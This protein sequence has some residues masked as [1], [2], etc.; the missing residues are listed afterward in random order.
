MNDTTTPRPSPP[1]RPRRR[2]L[3]AL[4]IG[5][6]ALLLLLGAGAFWLLGTGAGLRFALA[7][8]SG[9]TDGALHVG[10]AEG[11]LLGPLDL[12][13]IRYR[14]GQGTDIRIGSA[15]ADLAF[16]PLLGK[17]LHVLNL[18]ADDI[19]AALHAAKADDTSRN[20]GFNLQPPLDIVLD[21]VRIGRVQVTQG[22]QPL[23]ASNRLDLAGAWTGHGITVRQLALQSPDGHVDLTGTLAAGGDYRGDG[24]AGFAWKLGDTDY[25]GSLQAH[26]DGRRAHL[27]LD[28]AQPAVASLKLDLVQS[29]DY[30]WTASLDAPRFDPAP[31]LG[32]GSL[33]ALAVAL[34]GSGDRRGGRIDGQVGLND[35]TVQIQPLRAQ[36]SDDLKTLQLEQLTLGSPQ[37]PGSVEASGII[38]LDATPLEAQLDIHWKDLVLPASLVGQELASAGELSAEGSATRFHAE[39]KASVGPPGKTAQFSLNLDGTDR[40]IDLHTL[41]L[42][43]PKGTLQAKGTV[44]LRPALGWNVEASAD[45][46]DPGQLFAGWGGALDAELA[47]RG[48]SEAAGV[49]ATLDLRQLDGTL[50]QR[51]VRGKGTLHLSSSNVIDGQLEL[52][53]GGSTIALKGRPG[54]SNDADV[55]LAVASLGD[56][57]PDAGGRVNGHFNI[58]GK[59]PALSVNGTLSGQKI[60][61]Q[62]QKIDQLQL[63]LGMPDISKPSGKLELTTQ[64]VLAGGLSFEKIH[65]LAEGSQPDHR[66]TLDARGSQ[67]SAR[68][69]LHGGLKDGAWNGTLSTLQLDPQGLPQWRLQQPSRLSWKD[70]AM[71]ASE[72]CL[73][74]G[75]PLICAS[76]SQ[77]KGGNL[78]ASYRLRALPLALIINAAG[79]ADLPMRVDG[80]LA[81]DGTVH[82]SA[83]GAL[84]GH[85]AITSSHGSVSYTDHPEQPLLDYR[86][87]N[88]Q[89]QLDGASQSATVHAELNN[90]GLLD[91]RVGMRGANQALDGTLTL[92]LTNLAFVELLTS[93]VA[94][95]KGALD[96]QFRIGGT[97]AQ[98][99]VTGQATL[100]GFAGEV[101]AAGLKLTDGHVVLSTADARVFRIDGKVS[102][103]QGSLAIAGTAGLG[104]D[105]STEVTLKGSQFTAAD[106]PSAKVVVS[107]DLVIKQSAQGIDVGGKVTLDQADVN[108]AKL[109]GAGATQ[110]SPDVVV[111]DEKQQQAA[112]SKMPLSAN[113]TV[114]LG[115]KTHVVGMGLDG[116]LRGQLV[117]DERPGRAT[118]G[119]G[120]IAVS[121]TYKAYG[122]NLNIETGQLLFASTPVD[123]P[124]L[125]IRAVRRLNPNATI[126]EGQKVGLYISG[127]AQRPVLTVFSQPVME[128]SDALSYLITG[129][130]LSEVKGGE[131][132]M[133]NSAA[134]ALGSAGGDLLAKRIGSQLGVDDIGV[135][136]SDALN[137]GSAFTVGKY[138][139]PRLYLSYGV[140]LFDP[141]QVITL[142]YRI[143]KRWNFEAQ[144]AT[145]FSRASFNYRLEK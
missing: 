84:S 77:D 59:L 110:S 63:V 62:L 129:K 135:S 76:A 81:G 73:T 112:A 54:D 142:R 116:N 39:G 50:R 80:E 52:A 8:A 19:V 96:G 98:P 92:N 122:Q 7:R 32:A 34:H 79:L 100:D 18:K 66:L 42:N 57:L 82:R 2:W 74:A 11:R 30:T 83:A 104:A 16:W 64:G 4:A 43:Q 88:L 65:L 25:A 137:G 120:Q 141:G 53:S 9:L 123:N 119:Q 91:G 28:L 90:G 55:T 20:S 36:L 49:D 133:V 48:H 132:S 107:P 29:G 139:S 72:L 38:H 27:Q 105:A 13:D 22:G 67:L 68:F 102:S 3:R 24:K 136:S 41:A 130:P 117:V 14:D 1:P 60:S 31:L 121:G 44:T 21:N 87:L 109:P 138:L 134:Q 97:L 140:G 69:D 106:I 118:T 89:A 17:R 101:P 61:W 23:F 12:R 111:M 15:H 114:D 125:N 10:H 51:R 115:R 124:G 33:D 45:H 113:V 75:D 143:S 145:D 56:W 108:L 144:N 6:L 26:S 58:R 71:S 35:Q 131:G 86:N 47:S 126:D 103:G 93:E 78:E 95:V 37:V 70:G 94:H 40:Q 128:Q 5:V 46:F 127:T 99:A 85:A